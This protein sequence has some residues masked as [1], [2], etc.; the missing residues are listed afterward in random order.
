MCEGN[1]IAVV[2]NSA[3][4]LYPRLLEKAGS[5]EARQKLMN[6][7]SDGRDSAFKKG[8]KA[9]RCPHPHGQQEENQLRTAWFAGRK[10]KK[11]EI[12]EDGR[13]M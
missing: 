12:L 10:Q 8:K 3:V 5:V 1:S 2:S 11:Q 13:R 4:D 7:H 6:A 9:Q